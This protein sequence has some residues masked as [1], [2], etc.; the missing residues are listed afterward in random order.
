P[1]PLFYMTT[2]HDY[3]RV[4]FGAGFRIQEVKTGFE[5]PW[6]YISNIPPNVLIND[7]LRFL[8]KHFRVQDVRMGTSG[9]RETL[10]VRARFSSHIEARNANIILNGTRQW[11]SII[12]TQ[13][14]VNTAHARGA[15]IQDTAVQIE[16]DA[17]SIVG[18]AGYSTEVQA[19]KAI[20]IAKAS[21]SETYIWAHMY[22]GLPQM[23]AYTVRFGNLPIHTTKEQMSKYS[24]PLDM[25]WSMPNYTSV[26][27]VVTSLRRRLESNSLEINSFDTLIP[28][29][30]DGRVKAWVHFR[31]P[32][33][34][35]A[36]CK[37]IHLW[38]PRCTGRTR[39]FAYH[40]QSLSYS[41]PNNQ[42]KQIQEDVA[43]FR[44]RLR[45]EVQGSTM[46]IITFSAKSVTIQLSTVDGKDLKY[47]KA[48]FEQLLR[49]EVVK[50]NGEVLWDRFFSLPA[51]K[52]YLRKLQVI[53]SGIAIRGNPFR[54]RLTLFGNLGLRDIVKAVLIQKHS[55]LQVRETRSFILGSSIGPFMHFEFPSL[56]QTLGPEKLVLD[57]WKRELVVSG[58]IHDFRIARQAVQ[59][60][61]RKQD[62]RLQHDV[63][64][65]PVCLGEV[66]CP[67][68]LSQC[69]H[70]YCRACLISYLQAAIDNKF[71]PLTC[72]GD[73]N[74]CT[75]PLPIW[76]ARQVLS[77]GEFDSL[78][79]AAFEAY[80]HE[81][82]DEFHYCPSPNC[83]QV[84]R[85]APSGNALQCPSCLLRI[86]PQCHVEQHDGIDCP[87]R[88]GGVH[89]FNEWIKTHN[90]KNCPSCK[91]L[92]ERAEGCNHVTCIRCRTHICWVCMQTFPRGDGIYNHMRA[93]HGGIGNAFDNDGL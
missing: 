93:E 77:A 65:C 35:K 20:A 25:M 24:N 84:Y 71:F 63:A 75:S 83:M 78:A 5:T 64:S 30:R 52:T 86:C 18:Y 43:N 67:V 42:Y 7:I 91:V 72:L 70:S 34:A 4:K 56:S 23:A 62:S 2:V 11:D 39:T 81:R 21:Y 1:A 55:E 51:G 10:E 8:S 79:E 50:H 6:L 15:T 54:R 36:A 69:T 9:Q 53:H 87:D 28:P 40:M 85:P 90:V 19:K 14:P 17:P 29:Y 88:D 41:I 31:T 13:L 58:R 60:I 66:D 22:S 38:K 44:E 92:I 37:L 73:E 49:G 46:D 48:E 47:L 89:L 80:I 59:R 27:Q 82:P 32:A 16:W 33:S 74:N 61:Q 12:S 76:L 57:L 3:M 68:T 26:D 45:R